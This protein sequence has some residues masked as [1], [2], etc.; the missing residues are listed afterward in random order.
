M[1]NKQFTF[2]STSLKLYL[3]LCFGHSLINIEEELARLNTLEKKLESEV[4]RSTKML[5]NPNF[6]AK[7]PEA[8]VK[9]EQAKLQ[10]YQDQ[11]SEVRKQK[12]H[13]LK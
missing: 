1:L 9:E 13:L 2:S 10:K 12:E 7:A 4:E 8:K 5:S 6:L 11:L 3:R